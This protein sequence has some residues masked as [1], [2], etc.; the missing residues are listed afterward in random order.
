MTADGQRPRERPRGPGSRRGLIWSISWRFLRG[1]RSRLLD[2]TARAALVATS[3]GVMALVI[4]M[5]LMT[6]YRRDLRSKLVRGN[7]AVMAYPIVPGGAELAPETVAALAALPGVREARRVTYGQGSL[8]PGRDGSAAAGVD[9]EVTLRG[10]DPGSGLVGLGRLDLAPGFE[11]RADWS[12]DGLPAMILGDELARRLGGDRTRPL[13]L[14]VLG[15]DRG[16]PVFR[17]RSVRVAGTFS[18]GF[19]EF[20][21]GWALMERRVLEDLLG[22]AVGMALYELDLEDPSDASVIARRAEDILGGDYL[23]ADWQELNRELF[24]ALK[25]QQI[26]LFFVLGLIVLVSTFNV[27]SSLV[28]LVRDRMRDVGVLAAI[29]LTPGELRSVFLFYGAALGVAG[30]LCGVLLG[31]G[32]SWALT[33]FELIRFEPELAAIYFISSVPFRVDPADLLRVVGFTLL[34]TLTACWLPARKAGRV[35]PATALRYE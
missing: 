18:T 10:V 16:R 27:A 12:R 33:E 28:V 31:S 21:A 13:R 5:A 1:S 22:E 30:C 15:F 32:I 19:S 9:L 7:A 6:G 14:M 34:V 8:A 4:A 2:R 23:V 3:L 11:P 25:V 24:T 26:A 29:G 20:D 35:Q 17:Y